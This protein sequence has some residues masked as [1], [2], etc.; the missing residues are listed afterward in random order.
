M[1]PEA[2][3]VYQN[4]LRSKFR[5]QKSE[6]GDSVTSYG[7]LYF[8]FYLGL[9]SFKDKSDRVS[10]LRVGRGREGGREGG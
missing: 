4:G 9:I 7:S 3:Y 6:S 5:V 2:A 8:I 1:R 10:K